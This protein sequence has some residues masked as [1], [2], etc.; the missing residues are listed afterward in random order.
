MDAPW[1]YSVGL[2]SSILSASLIPSC[3]AIPLV[4]RFGL[5]LLKS[6]LDD[7]FSSRSFFFDRWEARMAKKTTTHLICD[8]ASGTKYSR[9]AEWSIPCVKAEWLYRCADVGY[10][11]DLEPFLVKSEMKRPHELDR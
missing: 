7:V 4:A 11:V 3:H 6:I 8:S 2:P 1:G 9:A 10:R 5:T